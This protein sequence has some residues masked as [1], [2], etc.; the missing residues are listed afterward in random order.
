MNQNFLMKT[1]ILVLGVLI[2]ISVFFGFNTIEEQSVTIE[3]L[4]EKVKEQ[5]NQISYLQTSKRKQTE[6]S[7]KTD[8]SKMKESVNVFIESIFHVEEENY[9]ERRSNAKAVVTQ[10]LFKKQFPKDTPPEKLLYEHD[11]SDINI[12]LSQED[13]SA[14]VIFDQEITNLANNRTDKKR[15]TIQVFL[16]KEG[17]EWIVN[18]FR[19][20]HAEPL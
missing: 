10:D 15:M 4:K 6:E 19:Q 5:E 9:D 8:E 2:V 18:D 13:Q 7:Q 11:V 12:Y 1:L 16:Q 3:Q 17:E 14:F 20:I